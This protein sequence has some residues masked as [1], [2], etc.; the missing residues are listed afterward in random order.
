MR[1]F[2]LRVEGLPRERRRDLRVASSIGRDK[3]D[4]APLAL[5]PNNQRGQVI[6]VVESI[7]DELHT[8]SVRAAVCD[9][10]DHAELSLRTGDDRDREGRAVELQ[11]A[12]ERRQQRQR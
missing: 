4:D 5:A 11:L 9:R 3:P 2:A 7:R 12:L 1:W 8:L 6:G 10:W